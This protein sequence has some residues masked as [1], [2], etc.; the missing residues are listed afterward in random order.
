MM[1]CG[2]YLFW[3]EGLETTQTDKIWSKIL[4]P[5]VWTRGARGFQSSSVFFSRPQ[6]S[7]AFFSL[8]QS[9]SVFFSLLQSSSAFFG[10]FQSSPALSSLF[11]SPSVSFS[12]PQSS[13]V[14]FGLLQSFPVF[15]SLLWSS[16]VS[17]VSPV[18]S[19]FFWSSLFTARLWQ[20][21]SNFGRFNFV[22]EVHL[23]LFSEMK[24]NTFYDNTII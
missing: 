13:P 12:L 20:I 3:S 9:S 5:V 4:S 2:I 6:S 15:F 11:Q 16:S 10:L 24:Q 22:W 14:F 1:G 19:S 8:L 18:A 23:L 21:C 7:P 17:P